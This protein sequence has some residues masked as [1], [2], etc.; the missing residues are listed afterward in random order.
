M[1]NTLWSY[2]IGL[3]KSDPIKKIDNFCFTTAFRLQ[4]MAALPSSLIL[5]LLISLDLAV[6]GILIFFLF[7]LDQH[8][9]THA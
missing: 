1:A 8:T 5:D 3:V 7:H 9:Y 4:N 6:V 2:E